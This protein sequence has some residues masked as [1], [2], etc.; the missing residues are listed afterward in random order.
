MASDTLGLLSI[1]EV[2]ERFGISPGMVRKQITA[3]SLP[4]VR[5]GTRVMITR[6]AAAKFMQSLEPVTRL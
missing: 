5:L 3:G 1:G 4:A 6:D 2:A